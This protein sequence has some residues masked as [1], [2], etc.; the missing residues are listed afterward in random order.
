MTQPLGYYTSLDPIAGTPPALCL[1]DQKFGS[2]LQKLTKFEKLSLLA[3]ISHC[4]AC[5]AR[6]GS[7]DFVF[8]L[9]DAW[10]ELDFDISPELGGLLK[11]LNTLEDG[12]LLGICQTLITN[13][14]YTEVAA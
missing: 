14:S 2:Y 11:S 8:T 12:D 4:L 9:E 6:P 3:I 1:L 7:E 10:A 5:N 13:H